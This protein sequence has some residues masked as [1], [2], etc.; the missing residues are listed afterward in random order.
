MQR[1][2]RRNELTLMTAAICIH[3]LTAH[4]VDRGFPL[5][6]PFRMTVPNTSMKCFVMCDKCRAEYNDPSN[7]RFHAQPIACPDCGPHIELTDRNRTILSAKSDALKDAVNSV[8]EGHIL[9]L[10]GLGRVSVNLQSG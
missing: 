3:S 5:L 1:M 6:N 8:L 9:A 10:K 7:R 4:I 2:S